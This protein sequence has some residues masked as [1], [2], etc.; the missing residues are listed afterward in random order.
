MCYQF[1][2]ASMPSL[3]SSYLLQS[4]RKRASPEGDVSCKV[5]LEKSNI[6][7]GHDKSEELYDISRSPLV[8]FHHC[9]RANQGISKQ[10]YLLPFCLELHGLTRY[11]WLSCFF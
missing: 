10:V 2:F 1:F 6:R 9:E 7:L 3:I 8:D 11:L 5:P 4:C